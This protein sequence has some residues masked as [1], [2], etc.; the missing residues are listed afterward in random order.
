MLSQPMRSRDL[1][2]FLA[3]VDSLDGAGALT[4]QE[5]LRLERLRRI[6][7]GERTLLSWG[8][9]EWATE[10]HINLALR[11]DVEPVYR[12]SLAARLKGGIAPSLSGA[13]GPLSYFSAIDVFTEYRSDT[14]FVPT[15][16]E[17]HRGIPH[18]LYG[19]ADSASVRSSDIFRAGVSLAAGRF[20]LETAVDYF[21]QGPAVHYP[22][23]FS[24][25]APP[26]TYFRARMG[27]GGPAYVHS[28]GLLRSQKDKAKYFYT[29]RLD[30]PALNGLLNVGINEVV[31]TGSTTDEQDSLDPVNAVRAPYRIEERGWEWVY[32]IPFVPYAFA[33][34]YVG[35]RDNVG[36]SFDV[37]VAA[38][39][40]FRWYLEFLIDDMTTP[41]TIFG[42]DWGNKWALTVGGQYFG[43]LG[44]RDLTATIE[45]S[46]VEPWVYTHF[47]GGSHR[48]THFG[49]S[50]GSPLGPN[51]DGLVA[52]CSYAVHPAHSLGVLARMERKNGRVRGG[53]IRDVWQE[54]QDSETKAF[55]EGPGLEKRTVGGVTWRMG[56]FG[57][58]RVD[59]FAFYESNGGVGFRADGG[60]FF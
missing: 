60:L 4:E 53:S 39:R 57:L 18:N 28:F 36:L 30:I 34:H 37:S 10:N 52:S 23:T 8:K 7:E 31:V 47:G 6:V 45:Y 38:P 59:A 5:S 1:A 33:E 44:G 11:G 17:P 49:Q 24:G 22:L 13:V 21:R 32:M 3:R 42:N 9:R 12:D 51:A 58:F 54:G 40:C 55:L 25:T 41:V 15:G 50:L 43:M 46:R 19:R 26:L 16:Y 29:H 14:V 35:D 20:D 2:A 27:L 48:Y 56:P